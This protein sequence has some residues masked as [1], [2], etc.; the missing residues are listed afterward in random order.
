MSKVLAFAWLLALALW[1]VPCPAHAEIEAP[2]HDVVE[3]PQAQIQAARI[4]PQLGRQVPTS[5]AFLDATGRHVTLGD[6]FH[7]RPIVLALAY[8]G[9]S[10]LCGVV[11]N[12]MTEGLLRM[13]GPKPEVLVVSI[14][15]HDTPGMAAL[16]QRRYLI[17]YGDQQA[18]WHFLTGQD[19]AIHQL[20]DAVGY[21][22]AYDPV[23]HQFAHAAS[24]MI[25]TPSGRVSGYL[26]GV[27]YA[28]DKLRQALDTAA[29][30]RIGSS[31]LTILLR[32][33]HYDPN[34]DRYG[35]FIFRLIQIAGCATALAL[36]GLIGFFM[37]RDRKARRQAGA[38]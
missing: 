4:D 24:L 18:P 2:P 9:C 32:C 35:A 36:A 3:V 10:N 29:S 1:L 20:A 11:L 5:L 37:L 25:L 33:F 12:S 17:R 8:Y 38:P 7:D 6:Y 23:S 26:E 31:P 15:P 16:R 27:D 34:R 22:Y 19:A 30:A 28:P 13:P 21:R 14:D